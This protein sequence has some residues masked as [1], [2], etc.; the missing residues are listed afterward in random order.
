MIEVQ[1]NLC[2]ADDYVVRFPSTI[3]PQEQLEV[4]AFSCTNP[5]YGHHAQIVECVQCGYVY[6]NP[7]LGEE[8]LLAAYT[9]R[10]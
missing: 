4:D 7:R 6:A 8:E 9:E 10:V 3:Q 2:G 1:C 5:G